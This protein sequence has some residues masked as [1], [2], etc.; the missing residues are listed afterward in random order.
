MLTKKIIQLR[1]DIND[2]NLIYSPNYDDSLIQLLNSEDTYINKCY[3]SML[4]KKITRII[5]K[6]TLN[7]KNNCLDG[8]VY[9]DVICEVEGIIYEKGEVIHNCLVTKVDN[10]KAY[11]INDELICMLNLDTKNYSV[12]EGDLVPVQVIETSYNLYA[13]KITAICEPPNNNMCPIP[14]YVCNGEDSD[15]KYND[16]LDKKIKDIITNIIKKEKTDEYKFFKNIFCKSD[17]SLNKNLLLK[18]HTYDEQKIIN[19][20]KDNKKLW[21][22]NNSIIYMK[23]NEMDEKKYIEVVMS[24]NECLNSIKYDYYMSLYKLLSFI[25]IYDSKDKRDAH[26]LLWAST[27]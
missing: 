7:C 14:V 2:I 16:D 27:M 15:I 11:C 12:S 26:K 22:E 25:D 19:E 4:I 1:L 23:D 6:G 9:I 10:N 21:V 24:F 20:F 18:H 3:K 5:N 13:P 17:I 8:S